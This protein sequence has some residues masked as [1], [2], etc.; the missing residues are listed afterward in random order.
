MLSIYTISRKYA[1][2][3]Q[4]NISCHMFLWVL[5]NNKINGNITV[6]YYGP[7]KTI[8]GRVIRV[9]GIFTWG[10]YRCTDLFKG[11]DILVNRGS[12]SSTVEGREIKSD[13]GHSEKW[14]IVPYSLVHICT[15]FF[16]LCSMNIWY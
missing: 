8:R 5:H 11:G 10:V 3:K 9:K 15:I 6:M 12:E 13:C 1:V 7:N 2:V 4:K 14:E 16:A